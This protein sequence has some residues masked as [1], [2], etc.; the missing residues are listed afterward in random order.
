MHHVRTRAL[1]HIYITKTCRHRWV[2]FSHVQCVTDIACFDIGS[3]DSIENSSGG[4]ASIFELN[5]PVQNWRRSETLVLGWRRHVHCAPKSK[6]CLLLACCHDHSA[7]LQQRV[8]IKTWSNTELTGDVSAASA[9]MTCRVHRGTSL[10]DYQFGIVICVCAFP[11]TNLP[12]YI[13]TWRASM[14]MYGECITPLALHNGWLRTVA[15]PSDGHEK[16]MICL[17]PL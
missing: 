12:R 17:V 6:L 3:G 5:G 13:C 14:Y 4:G 1:W 16:I 8:M 2:T 11:C 7:T 15:A 10:R 9:S